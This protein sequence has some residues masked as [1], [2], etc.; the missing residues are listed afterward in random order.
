MEYT[1]RY[2]SKFYDNLAKG[3]LV[4]QK[5]NKCHGYQPFPSPWCRHCQSTDLKYVDFSMKGKVIY[6]GV[7]PFAEERFMKSGLYPL[8]IG[9]VQCEEGPVLYIP[10]IEGID[11]KDIV[12]ANRL[13][14]MD[15]VI[16]TKDFGGNPIPVAKVVKQ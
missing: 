3:K 13:C 11:V 16:E 12:E 6:I 4:G 10:I 8:A 14:P 1:E 7:A 15:V 5:C 9:A 2:V